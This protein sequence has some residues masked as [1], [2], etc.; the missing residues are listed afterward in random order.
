MTCSQWY[1]VRTAT[2]RERSAA[3]ALTEQGFTTFLPIETR[4]GYGGAAGRKPVESPLI[5]GYLFVL[6]SPRAL[7]QVADTEGVHALI[8]YFDEEGVSRAWPIP[9][10]AI[11]EIQAGERSGAYDRTRL[12]KVAYRPKKG[13]AVKVTRGPWLSFVGKVLATPKRNRAHVMIEGPF[14]RGVVLDVA[15]L[16]AA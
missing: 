5:P 3:E 4:W 1:C 6:T 11:I 2:R 13:D 12:A 16:S 8:G 9:A 14:G 7:R 10:A 15:H